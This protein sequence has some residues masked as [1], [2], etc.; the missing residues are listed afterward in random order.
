MDYL[1]I[2]TE[3]LSV[4]SDSVVKSCTNSKNQVRIV[5]RIVGFIRTVHTQHPKEQI[6]LAWI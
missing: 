4:V 2:R 1:S 5:H 6:I 3:F